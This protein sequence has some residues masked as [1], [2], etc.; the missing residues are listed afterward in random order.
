MA[1]FKNVFKQNVMQMKKEEKNS[2]KLNNL[3][4]IYLYLLKNKKIK[5]VLDKTLK[6][7]LWSGK[8]IRSKRYSSNMTLRKQ[9]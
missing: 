9:E 6:T 1:K 2:S 7:D 5:I 3:D 8:R 4:K